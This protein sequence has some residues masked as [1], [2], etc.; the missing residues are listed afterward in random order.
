MERFVV[1]FPPGGSVRKRGRCPCLGSLGACFILMEL[2]RGR[3]ACIEVLFTM[4]DP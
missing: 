1:S 3:F 2:E 4:E